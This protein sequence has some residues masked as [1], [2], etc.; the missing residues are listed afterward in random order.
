MSIITHELNEDGYKNIIEVTQNRFALVIDKDYI[1][2]N[3][4]DMSEYFPDY[5]DE[6]YESDRADGNIW[7]TLVG[8]ANTG[9][10]FDTCC[11]EKLGGFFARKYTGLNWPTYAN[12]DGAY[13]TFTKMYKACAIK[14]G[15]VCTL[16]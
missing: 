16:E 13:E 11:R 3:F 9:G 15:L 8:E 7:W 5:D 4:K 12:G 6:F 1:D 10:I 14:D 2:K